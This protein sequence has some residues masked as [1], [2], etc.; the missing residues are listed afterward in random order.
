MCVGC[1]NVSWKLFSNY[2]NFFTLLKLIFFYM[3]SVWNGSWPFEKMSQRITGYHCNTNNTYQCYKYY[4]VNVG[5][6]SLNTDGEFG[7]VNRIHGLFKVCYYSNLPS[8]KVTITVMY[9]INT[10]WWLARGDLIRLYTYE[11]ESLLWKNSTITFLFF[12]LSCREHWKTLK[13][14]SEFD[15]ASYF[16]PVPLTG[17]Y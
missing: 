2:N 17:W 6:A 8:N 16:I 13:W 3:Y 4:F 9:K 1:R 15:A 5:I 14:V 10:T 7:I 11:T 12:Y